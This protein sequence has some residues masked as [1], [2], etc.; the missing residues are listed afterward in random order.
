MLTPSVFYFLKGNCYKNLLYLHRDYLGSIVA[1]TNQTGTITERRHFD[2]WG[3]LSH[4]RNA[5]GGTTLPDGVNTFLFLDRG[6]TGHEHLL[7]V[8]LVHMNGRLYDPIL[9][10]FLQPDNYVQDASNTQNY[11][12]YGYVMNNPLKYS[13]PSGEFVHIIVGAVI[14]AVRNAIF[15]TIGVAFSPGGLSNWSWKDFGYAALNGAIEGAF[16]AII[17]TSFSFGPFKIGFTP[18]FVTSSYGTSFGITAFAGIQV[19]PVRLGFEA[20]IQ[21]DFISVETNEYNQT[22]K[23]FGWGI[24]F[25]SRS[26]SIGLYSTNYWSSDGTSQRV[27]GVRVKAGDFKIR[28]E[29]EGAFPFSN[30][31]STFGDGGDKYRTTALEFGYSEYSLRMYL[32]TGD[33]NTGRIDENDP[34]YPNDVYTGGNTDRYRLGALA[35]GYKGQFI[36]VN[37]ENIRHTFQN[38][39]AHNAL[40]PQPYFRVLN[41]HWSFFYRFGTTRNYTLW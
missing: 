7:S 11:N 25:G 33:P 36:G 4:Y 14:G 9:H 21:H 13:D 24:D 23:T 32:Y 12:R 20:G 17:P 18:H 8:G 30:F 16:N 35:L 40:N 34:N 26:A 19:G 37:S 5:F 27:G 10:R 3:L 1:V 39:F 15:Y 22:T 6:Y 31:G 38:K 29:N 28:Y 41:N 2:A